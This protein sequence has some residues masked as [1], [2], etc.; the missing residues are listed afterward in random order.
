MWRHRSEIDIV[1]PMAARTSSVSGATRNSP[2]TALGKTSLT[3]TES[4][5]LYLPSSTSLKTLTSTRTFI[6]LAAWNVSSAPIVTTSPVRRSWKCTPHLPPARA[7][8]SPTV[9]GA[10][11]AEQ[12]AATRSAAIHWG[13]KNASTTRNEPPPVRLEHPLADPARVEVLPR[14]AQGVPS[15][16]EPRRPVRDQA[17]HG[18]RE[19]LPLVL[20]DEHI[21]AV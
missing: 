12:P 19:P 15:H 4:S 10:G 13:R 8:Q 9:A 14:A 7:T 3:G 16:L 1:F 21:D 20:A 5:S 18:L 11:G 6:V 2:P 17:L